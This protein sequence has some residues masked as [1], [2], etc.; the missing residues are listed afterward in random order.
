MVVDTT[1][2]NSNK[3][4][5]FHNCLACN[6]LQGF[7]PVALPPNWAQN[8]AFPAFVPGFGA[9]FTGKIASLARQ[10]EARP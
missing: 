4:A 6:D 2:H 8:D 7:V 5:T 1:I 3:R 10:Q 9:L